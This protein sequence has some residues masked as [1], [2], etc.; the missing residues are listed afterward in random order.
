M[1]TGGDYPIVMDSPFGS[2][3][4]DVQ[5]QVAKWIPRLANQVILFV[6][7]S[8][9]SAQVEN[10][11]RERVADEFILEVHSTKTG[12]DKSVDIEG[13]SHPYV[14]MNETTDG[15]TIRRIDES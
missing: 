11:I 5:E 6:S 9:Y 4:H 1:I 3:E 10:A 8:Q 2:L 15:T 13:R 12:D 7:G 14:I